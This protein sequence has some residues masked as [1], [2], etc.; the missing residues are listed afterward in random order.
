MAR[1]VGWLPH[2]ANLIP[3]Q[4]HSCIVQPAPL[5]QIYDILQNIL[6]FDSY[7]EVVEFY[8]PKNKYSWLLINVRH[9][10]VGSLQSFVPESL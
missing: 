7:L 4:T 2:N 3:A 10:V 8:E 1:A 5:R 9:V 6:Q